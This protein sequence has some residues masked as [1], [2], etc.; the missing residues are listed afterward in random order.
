MKFSQFVYERPDYEAVK[1]DMANH[2]KALKMAKA[3]D[4]VGIAEEINRIHS[5]FSSMEVLGMIRHSIDTSNEFYSQENDYWNEYGPLY[6]ELLN[7]YYQ[8]ML[9]SPHQEL[10]RTIFP[11]T[12]FLMAENKAQTFSPKII[13]LLQ[14]ENQLV[15][16]YDKLIASAVVEF[17]GKQLTLPQLGPYREHENRQVRQQATL[18]HSVYFA[19]QEVV[20]DRLFDQLV[21]VRTKMAQAL[22][23]KDYVEMSYRLMNRFDY[24]RE[25]VEVYRQEILNQV[26]PLTQKLYERQRNRLG[27]SKLAHYDLPLEYLTGNAIP[28]GTPTEIVNKG[29]QMYQELSPETGEFMTTMVEG[30]LLD[31]LSKPGKQSGGYCDYIPKDQAPF[32]FANFNGTSGDI[33]VLTHEAGHAFQVYQSRWIQQPECVFPTYESCEIHSMS[34]E[35]FTWPWMHLFFEEQTAKYQ[36]SHLAG[37]V[38]FLPYGVLVDHFQHEIYAQPNLTPAERKDVWRN[39]EK[40]YCPERDYS[41]DPF[42]EKG[43]YWFRQGHIF[44]SPFY[45]IDYTLAQ[46]C[47]FQF[48]KRNH[49]DKDLQAW[50]DYLA[51]CQIGGTKTFLEIIEV[52][53]LVS[54]FEKGALTQVMSAIDGYLSTIDDSYL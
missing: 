53:K 7:D 46:V 4:V 3:N 13:E 14:R 19:S 6:E 21:E 34:M 32:I 9:A 11:K 8:T 25:M 27:V 12:F 33:D 5:Q 10:L 41:D 44:A 20:I 50:S 18:A 39:L 48:W 29:L 16:E 40:I 2:V 43:T 35:F 49:V 23:F 45:Y 17:D 26:V 24:N 37:A 47:A 42:L 52:A 15:S 51:I 54:P 30:E 38:K 22:G 31:L 1:L 36:F 28:K